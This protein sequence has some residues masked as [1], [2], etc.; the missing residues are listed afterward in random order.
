MGHGRTTTVEIRAGLLEEL[1]EI[2]PGRSDREIVEGILREYLVRLEEA[3][4]R[5]LEAFTADLSSRPTRPASP[6]AARA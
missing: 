6:A 5:A 4:H 3:E 1:R 2:F